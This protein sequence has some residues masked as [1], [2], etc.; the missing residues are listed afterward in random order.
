MG[1][2]NPHTVTGYGAQQGGRRP[3]KKARHG[4]APSM[5]SRSLGA[6]LHSEIDIRDV[7]VQL[8]IDAESDDAISVE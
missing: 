8:V 1:L 2:P 6:D 4:G 7:N 3:K 5:S